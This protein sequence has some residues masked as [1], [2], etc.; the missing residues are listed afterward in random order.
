MTSILSPKG[1]LTEYTYDKNGNLV[2]IE[3]HGSETTKIIYDELGRYIQEITP[4]I[5]VNTPSGDVGFRYSYYT[6]GN[7]HTMTDPT[8]MMYMEIC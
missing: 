8:P 1:E 5:Y 6:S 4:N 3:Q 2:L 7:I